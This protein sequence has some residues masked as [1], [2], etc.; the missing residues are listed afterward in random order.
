VFLPARSHRRALRWVAVLAL[1]A[2]WVAP[3]AFPH[4]RGDDVLCL[5]DPAAGGAAGVVGGGAVGG[6]EHC[7]VCH[8]A[9]SFRT[10]F[11]GAAGVGIW[12]TAGQLVESFAE[13]SGRRPT[14]DRLPAR[15]PPVSS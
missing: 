12:L 14:I 2:G 3:A 6:P 10:A 9:R 7:Q 5:I 1:V 11:S 15:A 13:S 8:A 4:D